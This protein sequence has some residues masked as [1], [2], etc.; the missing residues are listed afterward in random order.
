MHIVAASPRAS[1][2]RARHVDDTSAAWCETRTIGGASEGAEEMGSGEG[3]E[4]WHRG[5][6]Q[7]WAWRWRA[8]GLI[9][10][11]YGRNKLLLNG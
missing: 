4:I 1:W 7:P 6:V 5:E 3:M 9:R 8:Q 11:H 10:D 2:Q